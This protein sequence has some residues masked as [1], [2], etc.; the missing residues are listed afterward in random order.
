M[1]TFLQLV[2]PLLIIAIKFETENRAGT[3]KPQSITLVL[4]NVVAAI[5]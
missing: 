4:Q 5:N 2:L 3:I 1:M